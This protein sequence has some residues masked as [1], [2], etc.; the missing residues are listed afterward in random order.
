MLGAVSLG[1]E[2]RFRCRFGTDEVAGSDECVY[3]FT[4]YLFG[5]HSSPSEICSFKETWRKVCLA[6]LFVEQVDMRV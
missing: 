2:L 4:S 5:L 1:V 6:R 3:G